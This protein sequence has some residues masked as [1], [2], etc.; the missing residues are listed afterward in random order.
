[1]QSFIPER[2]SRSET[3]DGYAVVHAAVALASGDMAV[4]TARCR[5]IDF[6]GITA[7]ELAHDLALNDLAEKVK[8]YVRG[9]YDPISSAEFRTF[10]EAFEEAAG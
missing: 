8:D 9:R 6:F 10:R 1:V 2:L 7:E 5:A 4:G 3:A